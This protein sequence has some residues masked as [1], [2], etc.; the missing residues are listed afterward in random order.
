MSNK[1]IDAVRKDDVYIYDS[2]VPRRISSSIMKQVCCLMKSPAKKISFNV[3][4]VM[5]QR[6][7]YDCGLHA[8]TAATDIVF[9]KDPAKSQWDL[10]KLRPHLIHC[11]KQ[12]KMMLFQ[13]WQKSGFVLPVE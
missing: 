5:R 1:L 3:V 4:D 6:N 2:L 10:Q 13:S 8:V 11:L 9:R 12:H 7:F